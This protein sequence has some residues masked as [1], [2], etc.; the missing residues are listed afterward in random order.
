MPEQGGA[1]N[2]AGIYY[3]NTLAARYLADLLDLS[4]LPP[5][6]RVVEVRLEAPVY[7]QSVRLPRFYGLSA[8]PLARANSSVRSKSSQEAVQSLDR[9][10]QHALAAGRKSTR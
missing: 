2:Q 9:A 6:E 3:Q 4:S 1:T 5:R 10:E 8:H 7:G